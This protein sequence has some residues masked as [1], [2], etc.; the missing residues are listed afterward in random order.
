MSSDSASSVTP[1]GS[2]LARAVWH[3]SPPSGKPL[4]VFILEPIQLYLVICVLVH[5]FPSERGT[6]K[7]APSLDCQSKRLD[8]SLP[9][10]R[11]RMNDK[12][13]SVCYELLSRAPETC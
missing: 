2:L 9:Q 6:W 13:L 8:L 1:Q 7:A 5:L 3:W 10:R 12:W 11:P 4:L